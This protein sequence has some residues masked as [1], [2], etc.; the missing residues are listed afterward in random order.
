MRKNLIITVILGAFISIIVAAA[1]SYLLNKNVKVTITNPP[2]SL[3]SVGNTTNQLPDLTEAAR[4]A[5]NAVV[6]VKINSIETQVYNDPWDF[7][8]GIP[9][10][11]EI[12]IQTYGSGV[13]ITKDGYIIT[14][15][16]VVK[17]KGDIEV[18][19]NDKN[20]YKAQFIGGDPSTDLALL[21]I[22]ADN[23]PYL[24]WGNSDEVK[25]GEWVLA[26]GNPYNLTSTVTAG[27]ISAKSRYIRIPEELRGKTKIPP[28]EVFIQTDAAVNPGNSGGALVNAKGELVGIITAIQSPTGVFAGYSFAIPSNIAKK[29]ANDL[30][31]YG[32]VKRAFLGV[33][34]QNITTQ[35]Q[36][37]YNIPTTKG[38]IVM[39]VI[40]GS[41]A[42]QAG[43]KEK[44]V[45]LAIDN[46]E[47]NTPS[48]LQEV[49]AQY[50]PNTK[51]VVSILRDG[52]NI[53]IEATLKS[54]EEEGEPKRLVGEKEKI[55]IMGAALAPL[56][57]EEKNQLG[58]DYGLKVESL[59]KNSKLY[60][61][62]VREGFIITKINKR[63]ITSLEEAKEILSKSRTFI[64]E[65]I[66]PDG[67]IAIY[68]FGT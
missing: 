35:V 38:V 26:V 39:G 67:S 10:K 65:G 42:H 29:V 19:L 5:L 56:S 6:H 20:I 22:D 60:S 49:I 44:D 34:V 11:I 40:E 24:E 51:V 54:V 55:K 12:P 52:K 33:L 50:D 46:K 43:L 41:G 36:K 57:D 4:K 30:Y 1:V 7:F 27:I 9:K 21:K 37:E 58:I 16:H 15:Y 25:I 23:L 8:W 61:I 59:D 32:K 53:K 47:I 2:A 64:I 17:H 31:K 63:K 48:E 66:Y 14:N 62:G 3:I 68:G 28:L 18:T 13:I 45:I